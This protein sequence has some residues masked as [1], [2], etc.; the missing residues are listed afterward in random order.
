MI[1]TTQDHIGTQSKDQGN[2]GAAG[3]VEAAGAV[4]GTEGDKRP[5]FVTV[6]KDEDDADSKDDSGEDSEDE[7]TPV[8]TSMR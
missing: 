6:S 4:G 5:G 1:V 8:G 3:G 2:G 7:R